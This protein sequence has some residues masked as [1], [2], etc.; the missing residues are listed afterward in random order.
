MPVWSRVVTGSVSLLL[1]WS[2]VTQA[3]LSFPRDHGA[4]LALRSEWWH[5]IGAL[6]TADNE[7]VGVQATW[8]RYAIPPDPASNG[9]AVGPQ[10]LSFQGAFTNITA[11]QFRFTQDL[12][13]LG[14]PCAR[15]DEAR[16]DLFLRQHAVRQQDD[17]RFELSFDVEGTRVHL[18]LSPTRAPIQHDH[19]R[20][21]AAE[22]GA[23]H[24]A[25]SHVS[26]SRLTA[27]GELTDASGQTTKVHGQMWY[28][29]QFGDPQFKGTVRGW[30]WFSVMLEDGSDLMFYRFRRPDGTTD[31]RSFGALVTPDG[32]PRHLSTEMF[33]VR[34]TGTWTSPITGVRY[35]A[36]WT[37]EVPSEL[38]QVRVTPI[39]PDQE[40]RATATASVTYWEGVSRFEG[41]R[42]DHAIAGV[43][44]VELMGY[45]EPIPDAL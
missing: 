15:A 44:Y 4:H 12:C 20:A 43:G 3:E 18:L 23:D 32:Q 27:D 7:L 38:L 42:G 9:P 13:L 19:A 37:I 6:T 35:P 1:V 40:L 36:S 10:P 26:L 2:S 39:L 34:M 17:G 11:Q 41:T 31:P 5:F 45:A 25:S 22:G 8:I 16:L 24:P 29:H 33:S 30:D 14:E 28:D 21:L